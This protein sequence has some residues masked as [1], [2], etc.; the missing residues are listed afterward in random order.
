MCHSN[1]KHFILKLFSIFQNEM[2]FHKNPKV[3]ILHL[4]LKITKKISRAY[5]ANNIY[6]LFIIPFLDI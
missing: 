4:H 3:R 6:T 5:H 2:Q 1:E